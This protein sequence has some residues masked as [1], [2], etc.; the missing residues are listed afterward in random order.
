MKV[1][2]LNRGLLSVAVAI[3]AVG[4]TIIGALSPA[5]SDDIRPFLQALGIISCSGSSPCEEGKNAGKGAGLEGISAKGKGVIGQ[6]T[7]N[8]TSSSNG[9]AGVQGQDLSTTG[10]NDTGVTGTSKKGIGVAGR[11]TSNIGTSG[12]SVDGYGVSGYS[13][14]TVGVYGNSTDYIGVFGT[15]AADGVAGNSASGVGVYGV[16]SIGAANGIGVQGLSVNGVGVNAVGGSGST[17]PALSIVGGASSVPLI[18]ACPQGTN[19]CDWTN[20]VFR[21]DSYGGTFTNDLDATNRVSALTLSV[22]SDMGVHRY[23]FADGALIVG[24]VN[25]PS[26][27]SININGEYEKNSSCVAGCSAPT[28]TSQGRGVVSYVATQSLP[29]I[30][31][32]GESALENGS[33]YV[34]LDQAFAN[35]IDQ[36]ANY[37][38]FIT[39]EGDSHGLYV[40]QKTVKGFA[41]RESM[42]GQSSIAFSY[43][44]VAKPLG[45]RDPRLPMVDMPRIQRHMRAAPNHHV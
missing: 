43:R 5:A 30:D 44:I 1:S 38:V 11:S 19:P 14:S 2:A 6:T 20:A 4:A 21:V 10:T 42:G 27:G 36:S 17:V 15:G 31:D 29:T 12:I 3:C 8:S 28:T 33:A 37:L 35:V 7:F 18:G 34:R 39:P 13:T 16:S 45:S 23:I 41:V 9:Q 32:F 25:V 40:T 22:G 24:Q 26:L